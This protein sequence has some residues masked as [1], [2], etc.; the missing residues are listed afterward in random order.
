MRLRRL[1]LVRYGRFTGGTLDFGAQEPGNPDLHVVYGP[2]EAGKSTA[3]NAWLDLLFG[4]EA[5]S[6]YAFVHPYAAMRIGAEVETAGRV[7][8]L[9]RIKGKQA[10]LL[11]EGDQPLPEAVLLGPL[12]GLDRRALREMFSLDDETLEAGGNSILDSQGE[13]GQLLFASGA[14]LAGFAPAL[15]AL[16]KTP[17]A[18]FRAPRSG[19]LS[20]LKAGLGT[21]EDERKRLDTDASGYKRLVQARDAAQA[22]HDV[23][24]AARDAPMVALQAVQRHQAALPGLRALEAVEVRL[25][26][27]PDLPAPPDGWAEALVVLQRDHAAAAGRLGALAGTLDGLG[28]ERAALVAD[29]L[30][31][32]LRRRI[33]AAGDLRSAHVEGVKDLPARRTEAETLVLKIEAA[34]DRL[35]RVGADPADVLPGRAAVAEVRALIEARSG[36]GQALERAQAE[37]GRAQAEADRAAADLAGDAGAAGDVATLQHL[38]RR[39]QDEAPAAALTRATEALD[40]AQAAL[41]QRLRALLPWRGTGAELAGL[42]PPTTTMIA[43]WKTLAV[44]VSQ[45]R[46]AAGADLRRLDAAIAALV[47]LAG[48]GGGTADAAVQARALREAAWAAHLARLDAAT[49]AAFETAMRRDD[50]ITAGLAET[51]AEARR[52]AE[53]AVARAG[54]QQERGLAVERLA[55]VEA[56]E[57]ALQ[58]AM[59]AALSACGLPSMTPEVLEGWITR[60]VVA[61]EAWD[62]LG[63]AVQRAERARGAVAEARE[64]LSAAL[65]L[66]GVTVLPDQGLAVLMARAGVLCE[67]AAARAAQHLAWTRAQGQVVTRRAALV[68][69]HAAL[70]RWQGRWSAALLAAKLPHGHEVDLARDDLATLDAFAADHRAHLELADRI[71]KMAANVAAYAAAVDALA[72]DLGLA[73][74]APARLGDAIAARLSAAAVTAGRIA[75]LDGKLAVAAHETDTQRLALSRIEERIAAMVAGFGAADAADLGRRLAQAADRCRTLDEVRRAGEALRQTLKMASVDAARAALAGLDG[76][77]LEAESLGLGDDVKARGEVAQAAFAALSETQRQLDAVGGD[78]AVLR[79]AERRETLLLEIAE[80]ARD[81]LARKLGLIAVEHGLRRYRD[82]HRSAM[83]EAASQAFRTMTRGAYI[84][85]ATQPDGAREVLVALAAGGGSKRAGDLSKGTRFQLYLSLRVAAYHER[86]ALGPVPPFIADDIMETFDD[87]RAAEA[88]EV[89]AGMAGVGQVI[90]LTHHQHLCDIARRVCPQV[91]LHDLGG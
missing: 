13:V 79:L 82:Q 15:A 74:D 42:V 40:A 29:P 19:A 27:M 64:G 63:A 58:A 24:R 88:F 1:D 46:G 31:L 91:R 9:S 65:A 28:A 14:G 75:E 23:A 8:A 43:G 33:E 90:Y 34:L 62:A 26:G 70:E 11:G 77:V 52:R 54:L 89:L 61:V 35:G 81:H 83:I 49:A 21:L 59:A 22:A 6:G 45:D 66:A 41:D 5:Q 48:A 36:V 76:D 73:A 50:A 57:P 25:A 12:G 67:A 30:V 87:D 68:E 16:R 60:R 84:G 2:N 80:G 10:T 4:I 86:A 78:D 18:F 56:A 3:L 7:L 47:V 44:Q 55:A 37:V 32:A 53:A 20:D 51:L 69:A 17:D 38:L 71:G 72:A 39:L 85:L